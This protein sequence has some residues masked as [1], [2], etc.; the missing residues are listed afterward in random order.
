MEPREQATISEIGKRRKRGNRRPG[1]TLL[2]VMLAFTILGSSLVLIA[3]GLSRHLTVLQLI[4]RSVTAHDLAD[5]QLIQ[6]A[7]R[8]EEELKFPP[9]VPIEG[10]STKPTL[11]QKVT[12]DTEP[13]KGLEIEEAVA[14]VS[15]GFRDQ[16]RSIRV[17]TGFP[18]KK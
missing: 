5:R 7:V 18:V 17:R 15:W 16:D 12:L 6:E 3:A 8:R 13:V 1:F 4:E 10:F 11:I 2:E 14:E 9:D